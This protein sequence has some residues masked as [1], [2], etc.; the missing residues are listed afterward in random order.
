MADTVPKV[1]E[2]E[3]FVLRDGRGRIRARPQ[4][5]VASRRDP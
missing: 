3:R 5:P 1:V 4:R 2:A